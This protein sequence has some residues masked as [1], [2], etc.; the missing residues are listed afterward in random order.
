MVSSLYEYWSLLLGIGSVRKVDRGSGI[1]DSRHWVAPVR[2]APICRPPI[3]WTPI[4]VGPIRSV[5]A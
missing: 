1:V 4:H 3:C 5:A 2:R